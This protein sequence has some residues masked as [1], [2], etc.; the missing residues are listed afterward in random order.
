MT[1]IIRMG[2]A[3]LVLALAVTATTSDIGG[4][5]IFVADEVIDGYRT[6]HADYY[7]LH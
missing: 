5:R 1:G 6:L 7:G 3:T 2:L 4:P